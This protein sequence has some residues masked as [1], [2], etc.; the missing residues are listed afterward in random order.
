VLKLEPTI[1]L[2]APL[3]KSM[4]GRNWATPA[5]IRRV[6]EPGE[7]GVERAAPFFLL[8]RPVPL[9]PMTSELATVPRSTAVRPSLCAC[10]R[11]T[12]E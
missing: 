1:C 11:L 3:C 8:V 5:D 12:V 9:P 6:K 4:H 7:D 2:T 10:P